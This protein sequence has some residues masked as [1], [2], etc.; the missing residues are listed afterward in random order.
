MMVIL[1]Q[2]F[3]ISIFQIIISPSVVVFL[4]RFTVISTIQM[5]MCGELRGDTIYQTISVSLIDRS[6]DG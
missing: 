3:D 6:T 5:Y 4:R 1:I 2:K